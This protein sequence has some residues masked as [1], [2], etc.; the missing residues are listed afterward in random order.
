MLWWESERILHG[1]RSAG[2]RKQNRAGGLLQVEKPPAPNDADDGES[3]L[4]PLPLPLPPPLP[5]PPLVLLVAVLK[6]QTG[7]DA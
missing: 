1:E 7:P 3:Y 4:R 2:N 5:P 6:D